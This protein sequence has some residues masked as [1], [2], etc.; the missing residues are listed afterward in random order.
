MRFSK[1][2]THRQDNYHYGKARERSFRLL[3]TMF[4]LMFLAFAI[5]SSVIAIQTQADQD[6]TMALGSTGGATLATGMTMASI[7]DIDDVTDKYTQGN[8]IAMEIKLVETSQI[9]NTASWPYPN[10]SREVSDIPMKDGEVPHT[11]NGHNTPKYI[12]SGELGD[13][14]IDPTKSIDLV[15]GDTYRDQVLNFT[16]EKGG[17]K[18]IVFFRR[19]ESS[20]WYILG[21]YD[22][23]M[24]LKSYEVK[25]DDASVAVFKFENK[26][27]RQY[28]KYTGSLQTEGATAIATDSTA[29]VVGTSGKYETAN[30]NASAKILAT[31]SGIAPADVGR[32]ITVYGIGGTYPHTIEDDADIFILKNDE[33]WT[34]NA[35][36][37]IQFQILDTG[38]LVEIDRIQT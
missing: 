36:S 14:T 28:Y 21:T 7:G 5:P 2:N 10:V 3:K 30:D 19:V 11:F 27:L 33:T 4:V 17:G 37:T 18:F 13:Y 6:I 35:G 8:N 31:V 1:K 32:Y 22:K 20:Q 15:L 29:L 25:N 24:R 16:E 34:G 12:A 9:D 26:S 23:P 38:T